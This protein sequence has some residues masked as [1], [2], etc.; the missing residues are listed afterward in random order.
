MVEATIRSVVRVGNDGE[1]T[2]NVNVE[3]CHNYFAEGHLVH[4]CDDP[5]STETAESDT[6]RANTTRKFREG[7]LNRLNDQQRSALV[8]IMQR[9]HG[10]DIS[11]VILSRKMDFIHL[12]LPMRFE[13]ERKCSTPIF[14]DPRSYDGELLDPARFPA[15]TVDALER[16]M[17]DYA[18]NGQ[19]QQRPAPRAGGM[20]KP[21]NLE[22][23]EVRPNARWVRAWDL[24]ATKDAGSWT[25]GALVGETPE[26]R[27]VIADVI[28]LRG[29]PDEVEAAILGTAARDGREVAISLPQDPGQAGKAQALHLLRRLHGYIVEATPETGDKATRA[30]PIA[31]QINGGNALMVRGDWNDTL[32]HEMRGFPLGGANDQIDAISRAYTALATGSMGT[33]LFSMESLLSNGEAIASPTHCDAVFA[34]IASNTKTGKPGDAV[35]VVYWIVDKHASPIPLIVADWGLTAADS[36]VTSTWVPEVFEH[37]EEMTKVHGARFGSLGVFT[38]DSGMGAVLLQQAERYGFAHPIESRLTT[39]GKAERAISIST[40]VSEGSVKISRKA[41]ERVTTHK[42]IAR[43]QLIGELMA[44]RVGAKDDAITQDSLLEAF[45]FGVALGV[46]TPAGF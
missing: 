18:F 28:R 16:D 15:G 30:G 23:I 42:Q 19:Y 36:I 8:V 34:T 10:E 24:A 3:P 9:L 44:F 26:L 39:M 27:P 17:G 4:N 2:F 37:L 33:Q 6:E 13:I 32:T 25:A 5:H 11:G 46:G 38:D 45:C 43:N 41:Y 29:S 40:Y 12:C 35:S 21:D 7:A 31:S 20:I 1:P 14:T 22:I